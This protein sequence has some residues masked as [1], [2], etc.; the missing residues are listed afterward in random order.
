MSAAPAPLD[1]WQSRPALDAHATIP[2]ATGVGSGQ[3]SCRWCRTTRREAPAPAQWLS[4]PATERHKTPPTH[5]R[6][7]LRGRLIVADVLRP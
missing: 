5:A 1:G 6:A 4:H 7:T 2:P 3:R